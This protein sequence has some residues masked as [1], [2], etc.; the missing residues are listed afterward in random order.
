MHRCIELKHGATL[1]TSKSSHDN[2]YNMVHWLASTDM[3][4][5]SQRKDTNGEEAHLQVT[6]R[7]IMGIGTK[8]K[9]RNKLMHY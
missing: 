1:F 6:E 3:K 8:I 2:S 7:Q 4:S 9:N 5:S